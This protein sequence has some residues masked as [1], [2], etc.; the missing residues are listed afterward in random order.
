MDE[1][2]GVILGSD[3]DSRPRLVLGGDVV[4]ARSGG[5]GGP[6]ESALRVL[7]GDGDLRASIFGCDIVTEYEG[8]Y[9]PG[10]GWPELFILVLDPVPILSL[11]QS[12]F[13]AGVLFSP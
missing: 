10:P 7:V 9:F 11:E 3:G 5:E 2:A 4:V 12:Y 1:A 6:S 8:S 13:Q